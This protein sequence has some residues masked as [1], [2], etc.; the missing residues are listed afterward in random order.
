MK[1]RPSQSKDSEN[2]D[3]GNPPKKKFKYLCLHCTLLPLPQLGT[4]RL[5]LFTQIRELFNLCLVQAVDNGVFPLLNMYALDLS[6]QISM[7]TPQAQ[8]THLA[9]I[10]KP[11]LAHSHTAILLQV[12]PRRIHNSDV[13]FLVA[14]N[15]VRLCQLR[16]VD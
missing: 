5:S 16:T 14:L 11:N 13:V 2:V 15:T 7:Q 9:L 12:T 6:Q 8:N 3:R 10:L 4:P 1:T